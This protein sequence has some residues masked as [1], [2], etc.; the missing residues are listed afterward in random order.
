M[1][2]LKWIWQLPQHIF[3]IIFRSYWALFDLTWTTS[4]TAKS[5]VKKEKYRGKIIYWVTKSQGTKFSGVSLGNYI[6]I[7]QNRENDIYI[8]D[9]EYGHSVQSIILGPLYLFVVGI[10]SLFR[11][12]LV[13]IKMNN[14][15][16][17][18]TK[19][20]KNGEIKSWSSKEKMEE[21]T[22]WYYSG[23]PEKQAD[24]LG[25]VKREF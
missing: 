7:N 25:G 12:I 10:P 6:F 9:H 8:K 17:K 13:S 14:Y 21:L 1:I 24:D 20:F 2:I 16:K 22:K 18:Q 11:N 19:R 23:W 3:A 15:T 4:K 5:N